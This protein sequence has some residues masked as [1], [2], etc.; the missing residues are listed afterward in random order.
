MNA[1][2]E[3]IVA[4][5]NQGMTNTAIARQLH[6]DKHRVGDIRRALG[7]PNPPKQPLTLDEKW[8]TFTRPVDGG[9]LEWL[10]ERGSA[11]STPVMRY[12]GKSHSPAGIAFRIQHGREAMGQVF[13]ECG[14]KHCVAPAHVDDETTRIRTREQ[15]R[16]L[17]GGRERKP[18]CVHGHNQATYGRYERD[19]RAY[20]EECK[21]LQRHTEQEAVAR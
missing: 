13:A 8:A 14:F 16:Y 9:H 5:L 21:R 7:I 1:T 15:L 11:S 19:G 6:C 3:Q 10:G 20:C 12:R 18:V 4:L 2:R 17:T